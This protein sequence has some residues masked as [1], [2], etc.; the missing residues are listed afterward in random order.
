MTGAVQFVIESGDGFLVEI[1]EHDTPIL[2]SDL[3]DAPR[4]TWEKA[5]ELAMKMNRLR[6]AALVGTPESIEAHRL[7]QE[8]PD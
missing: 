3:I 6:F 1:D 2:V 8:G 4:F 5:S 7:I